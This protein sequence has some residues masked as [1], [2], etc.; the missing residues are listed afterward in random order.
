MKSNRLF[1]GI[2]TAALCFAQAA[3][4]CTGIMLSGIDGSAVR[5]RTMEWGA[6]DLLSSVSVVPPGHEM[7]AVMP[8]GSAGA[9][10][11]VRY[12]FAGATVLGRLITTDGVNE[13]G[14]SGGLFYLPGFAEYPDFDPAHAETSLAPTDVVNY[15][16][17]NF[18]TVAEARAA[19]ETMHIVDVVE[20]SL[21]FA[22]PL[23]FFIA[24]PSGDRI[25]I[26]VVDKKMQIHEAPLGVI[27]NAPTYDWHMTNLRNYLNLSAT[28]LPKR[29]FRPWARAAV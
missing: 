4:A 21:G 12:G 5:A 11:T 7:T 23:H 20:P 19:L 8:D 9:A 13:A 15:V 6:F 10:W 18:A 2:V 1:A 14:L 28:E 25:V 29:T 16:L 27:T 17:S 24:D 3:S 22:A 26:E